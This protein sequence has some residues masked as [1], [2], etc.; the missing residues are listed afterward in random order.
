MI[1]SNAHT[2][3]PPSN[4]NVIPE[5]VT[6]NQVNDGFDT[7]VVNTDTTLETNNSAA[8]AVNNITITKM[9][10]GA[11]DCYFQVYRIPKHLATPPVGNL[12][13][14]VTVYQTRDADNVE[15]IFDEIVQT[16]TKTSNHEPEASEELKAFMLMAEKKM[17]RTSFW[18]L[19]HHLVKHA[20]KWMFENYEIGRRIPKADTND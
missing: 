8:P 6:I 13:G 2:S 7:I 17:G 3:T 18:Q 20:V 15:E 5:D 1:F 19:E 4:N 14:G 11:P 16:L 10:C 9:L 12:F